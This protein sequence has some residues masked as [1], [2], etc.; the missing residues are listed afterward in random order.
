M[1]HISSLSIEKTIFL[2]YSVNAV[3]YTKLSNVTLTLHFY[4]KNDHDVL[5]FVINC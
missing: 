2:L 3:D 1:Y 4:S 5:S